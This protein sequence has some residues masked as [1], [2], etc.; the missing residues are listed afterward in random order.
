M[1][2]WGTF[3]QSQVGQ[4]SRRDRLDRDWGLIASRVAGVESRRCFIDG[5]LVRMSRK[6]KVGDGED[7]DEDDDGGDEGDDDT[8]R[9]LVKV[10][11]MTMATE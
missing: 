10:D 7:D 1:A 6:S 4:Q 2:H 3:R 8:I 5:F 9:L 11:P